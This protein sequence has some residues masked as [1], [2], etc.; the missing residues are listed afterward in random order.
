MKRVWRNLAPD[1]ALQVV[2]MSIHAARSTLFAQ[3]QA[4][5]FRWMTLR[6]DG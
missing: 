6:R 2:E 1:A 5:T 4:Y 3:G